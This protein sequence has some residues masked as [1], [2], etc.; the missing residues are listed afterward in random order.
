VV[1]GVPV[2]VEGGD[3][4]AGHAADSTPAPGASP[5]EQPALFAET[6]APYGTGVFGR[7]LGQVQD[8]FVVT[9]SD[10]EV[11][12]LDQHAAHERVIVERLQ[13]DLAAGQAPGQALLYP[14]AL[15]LSP[16]A[17]AAL[18]RWRAPLE[19]LGFELDGLGGRTVVLRSAPVLLA[20]D[21]P[22]RLVE[23]LADDLGGPRAGEPVI[24]RVLAFVACRAAI[25]ANAPLGREQ[26]ERLVADLA[27]TSTP[28]FCP[29]GRPTMS[30]VAMADV[31]REVRRVW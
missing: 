15:E 24:D 9:A 23:A 20:G 6:R 12:F 28:F 17:R 5:G 31:R 4:A 8:T 10:A 16:P 2:R 3:L 25:K 27:R 14:V 22:R 18:E 19:R 26:M 13:A 21:E 30:R 11:F 1:R 29:H 7:V